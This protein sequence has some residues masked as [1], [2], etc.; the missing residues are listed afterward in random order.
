LA[1]VSPQSKELLGKISAGITAGRILL[2]IDLLLEAKEHSAKL[3]TVRIPL[4]LAVIKFLY[5]KS[6][7]A[8]PVQA[9]VPPVKPQNPAPANKIS[10]PQGK[11]A[12]AVNLD[13]EEQ[14][15]KEIDALV[16]DEDDA[17]GVSDAS[18]PA[19]DE[20]SR[21]S[22]DLLFSQVKAKWQEILSHIQKVRAAIASHLS[23][24][25]PVSSQGSLIRIAFHKNDYFHKEIVESSKNLK[26]IEG[27]VAHILNKPAG[28]KFIL[29]D[30]ALAVST[31]NTNIPVSGAG[32]KTQGS[33]GGGVSAD[34][35]A[36]NEKSNDFIN[37]LLDTFGGKLDVEND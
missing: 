10:V 28:I 18:S 4:E 34:S 27:V 31:A 20:D 33:E 25:L 23:Y 37:D 6:K 35:G 11:A 21:A 9:A 15:S 19:K 16:P 32:H 17:S 29:V 7:D 36:D 26:F 22:D 13:T 14:L 30:K 2:V 1:E 24:S 8:L 3:N 5:D 12:A